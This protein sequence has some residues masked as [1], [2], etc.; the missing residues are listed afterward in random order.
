MAKKIIKTLMSLLLTTIFVAA[1]SSEAAEVPIPETGGPQTYIGITSG[2]D[3]IVAVTL[4]ENGQAQVYVC[5]GEQVG[6]YFEGSVENGKFSLTSVRGAKLD[7]TVEGESVNGTFS[8]ADG[9]PLPFQAILNDE[10]GIY[11]VNVS[12]NGSM[13]GESAGQGTFNLQPSATGVEG[14]ATYPSGQEV[15]LNGRVVDGQ[16]L[17]VEE[18]R[19][20][21][22][23]GGEIE[24]P[25][26]KH[27]F[28]FYSAGQAFTPQSFDEVAGEYR[29][30]FF[31]KIMVGGSTPNNP[32]P[33]QILIN[34]YPEV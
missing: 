17:P 30:V 22:T 12:G 26:D 5:D 6:E 34:C 15:L 33:Q 2:S 21:L 16:E 13:L 31:D 4:L 19:A 10:A 8:I 27:T 24:V 11:V 1:C 14:S 23:S 32:Q 3:E 25:G 9:T 20:P 18:L 28:S 29:F 7:A